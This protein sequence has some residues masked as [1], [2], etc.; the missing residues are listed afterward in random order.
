MSLKAGAGSFQ[1]SGETALT[2]FS[3]PYSHHRQLLAR[4]DYARAM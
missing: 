3:W 2:F 1:L 4:P